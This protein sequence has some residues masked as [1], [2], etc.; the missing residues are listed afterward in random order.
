MIS[1]ELF[2]DLFEPVVVLN[3]K[4][5]IL[6]Y[7][8]SFLSFFQMT[9]RTV[10]KLG[11]LN[12]FF[13]ELGPNFTQFLNNFLANQSNISP[14]LTFTRNQQE[15]TAILKGSKLFDRYIL[16]IK[17]M[18]VE[19]QLYDKYK[20]QIEELKNSHEQILQ[21]DKLKALGE[22]S[23]NISHEINN[24]LTVAS[25]N[26]ELLGFSLESE[27]LNEQKENIINCHQN[28]TSSLERISKIIN[29]MKDFLH[30]S[31]DVK[32]YIN[33]QHI[34]ENSILQLKD[35]ISDS[36]VKIK[37]TTQ[38]PDIII[39]ANQLKLEQVIINILNNA[40][41]AVQESNTSNPLINI[42]IL[43]DKLKSS[44]CIKISDNGPGIKNENREKIFQT[45][46]TTKE[47]GKGTGLGLSISR[48]IIQS[49]QGNL[50]LGDSSSGA[51]FIITLPSIELSNYLQSDWNQVLNDQSIQ[52]KILFVDN[53]PQILNL[54]MS[55]LKNSPYLFL[56][57]TSAEEALNI[58]KRTPIHLLITDINM[59]KV[60]GIDLV[61]FLR[62][63]GVKIPTLLLSNK[64]SLKKYADEKDRLNISGMIIKPFTQDELFNILKKTIP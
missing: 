12:E 11:N 22:M 14:E 23:A 44:V 45:F 51:Q 40:I 21:A 27:D 24:P 20:I 49:H 58:I 8:S 28:I 13:T 26:N 46:F 47:V 42:E 35:R 10:L 37:V 63:K 39:L 4:S 29:N 15:L 17:D 34:I 59:P 18:T 7:N 6:Y 41:D 25:G 1:F 16:M 57:A 31:D 48:R 19:K 55:Y 56:G 38:N 30:K 33:L 36:D 62:K 5:E 60:S 61:D 2:D 43:P 54:C 32:E 3:E 52:K 9:P 64:D 50:E 53:E